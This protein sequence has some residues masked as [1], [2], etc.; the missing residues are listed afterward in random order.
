MLEAVPPWQAQRGR[1]FVVAEDASYLLSPPKEL[2]T[3]V[4]ILEILVKQHLQAS[5][6]QSADGPTI[7]HLQQTCVLYK[8]KPADLLKK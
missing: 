6:N 2:S 7:I 8:G 4:R 1:L 5:L 3:E